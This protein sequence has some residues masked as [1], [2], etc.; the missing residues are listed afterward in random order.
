MDQEEEMNKASGNW[1]FDYLD[2][3]SSKIKELSEK[4]GKIRPYMVPHGSIADL[5]R[6]NT[7]LADAGRNLDKVVAATESKFEERA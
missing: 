3:I 6:A 5:K 4:L 2:G 7:Y 1:A